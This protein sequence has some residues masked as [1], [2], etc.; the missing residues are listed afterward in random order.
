[1]FTKLASFTGMKLEYKK[2]KKSKKGKRAKNFC[3]FLPFLPFLCPTLS[4]DLKPNFENVSRHQAKQAKK[5]RNFRLFRILS[6]VWYRILSIYAGTNDKST[7]GR[8]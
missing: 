1:T 3:L 8:N 5:L 2:G 6:L 4:Y 7:P